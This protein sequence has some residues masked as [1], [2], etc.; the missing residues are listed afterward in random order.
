MGYGNHVKSWN[1]MAHGFHGFFQNRWKGGVVP[2]PSRNILRKLWFAIE[3]LHVVPFLVGY[4]VLVRI[5]HGYMMLHV[6][7]CFCGVHQPMHSFPSE[8]TW[9]WLDM[10]RVTSAYQCWADLRRCGS[11]WENGP[12]IMAKVSTFH[13]GPPL[14]IIHF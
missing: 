3:S 6:I 7:M 1:S 4:G 2:G 14:V 9:T 12:Q 13:G 5:W 11:K 8:G 10:A